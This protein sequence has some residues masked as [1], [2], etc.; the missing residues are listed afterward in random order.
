MYT[1]NI[2]INL[3]EYF[4]QLSLK[5]W[6]ECLVLLN[7]AQKTGFWSWCVC[8]LSSWF[9]SPFVCLFVC[10]FVPSFHHHFIEENF[11]ILPLDHNNLLYDPSTWC[12]VVCVA[13]KVV[14]TELEKKCQVPYFGVKHTVLLAFIYSL[15]TQHAVG[16]YRV[17]GHAGVRGNEMADRHA[18]DG[19]VQW[20]VGPEPFLG[21]SRQ[22]I[23]GKIKCW[24]ANQHLVLWCG[25]CNTQRQAG[26]LISGPYLATRAQLL[27]FNRTQSRVV[28][29]LRTG[30]NTLRRHLYV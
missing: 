13:Q 23:R 24:M 4:F 21:V 9:F 14:L 1:H 29:G 2:H 17:P 8:H 25:P 28:I 6:L 30:H 5:Y 15:S 27:S 16:L 22:N 20:C 18:R 19:S 10:L 12:C 3:I 7:H 26:E 11:T